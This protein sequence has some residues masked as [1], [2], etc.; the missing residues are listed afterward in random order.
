MEALAAAITCSAGAARLYQGQ[1]VM[2]TQALTESPQ[3]YSSSL[4]AFAMLYGTPK[5]HLD[6]RPPPQLYF[7][8]LAC[9]V[10]LCLQE[11]LHLPIL[12]VSAAMP[13]EISMAGQGACGAQVA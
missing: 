11:Q 7:G 6:P 3:R 1:S 10:L 13:A 2:N 4:G 12:T 8:T 5:Q 9:A